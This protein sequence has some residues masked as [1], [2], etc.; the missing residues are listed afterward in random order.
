MASFPLSKSGLG[1]RSTRHPQDRPPHLPPKPKCHPVGPPMNLTCPKQPHLSPSATLPTRS[2]APLFKLRLRG[3]CPHPQGATSEPVSGIPVP[4]SAAFAG[5][6]LEIPCP[7]A[8]VC[9]GRY[10]AG[11]DSSAALGASLAPHPSL[12]GSSPELSTH[13]QDSTA[14]EEPGQHRSWAQGHGAWSVILPTARW[15]ERRRRPPY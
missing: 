10:S 3:H 2:P 11:D 13:R 6:T 8:P 12:P 9:W 5:E 4:P 14:G 1:A 7:A 15:D